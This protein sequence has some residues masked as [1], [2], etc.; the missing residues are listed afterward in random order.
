MKQEAPTSKQ[1]GVGG[2]SSRENYKDIIDPIVTE[3]RNLK[4]WVMVDDV[5]RPGKAWDKVYGDGEGNHHII[6]KEL[7]R[8][9]G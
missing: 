6:S 8:T 1:I 2:G 3:K 7:I 4:P 9:I 5:H